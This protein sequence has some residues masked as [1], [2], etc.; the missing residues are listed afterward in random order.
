M[1]SF[2][3]YRATSRL[4]EGDWTHKREAFSDAVVNTGAER[5]QDIEDLI[6]HRQVLTP[7]DI[8]RAFRLSE[9]NIFPGRAVAR[10]ALLPPA[11]PRRSSARYRDADRPALHAGSEPARRRPGE[12]RITYE[13]LRD[14]NPRIVCCSLS[15][16]GTT[17]PR[18]AEGGYDYVIQALAG[19][20]SL[21][22][23]PDG[24]PAKSGAL[25]RRPLRR[26]R[27]PRSR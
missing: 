1:S 20:M 6:L 17:G 12:L 11:R 24:P 3:Q 15:G 10:A 21:T 7:L 22:G 5:A 23:E 26:L 2:V 25:A 13:H 19:W 14:V 4:A 27:R 18:A 8:K 16:F 9:G